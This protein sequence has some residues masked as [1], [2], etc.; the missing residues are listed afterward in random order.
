MRSSAVTCR[1]QDVYMHSFGAYF[2]AFSDPL[3]EPEPSSTPPIPNTDHRLMGFKTYVWA[4]L[5]T[6]A[7]AVAYLGHRHEGI[8]FV[9]GTAIGMFLFPAV[10]LG[11]V[12]LVGAAFK[13]RPSITT[14]RAIFFS[15]FGLTVLS[16]FGQ[17]GRLAGRRKNQ[18]LGIA[19]CMK[20]AH[21]NAAYDIDA[22]MDVRKYCECALAR[23]E[24]NERMTM[25]D[26]EEL[27]DRNSVLAHELAVPCVQAAMYTAI[28]SAG[29]LEGD[30]TSDT[31]AVLDTPK[32]IKVKVAIGGVEYYFL[33]DSGASD[34][35]VSTSLEKKL[36]ATGAIAGY[37]DSLGYEM[38]NGDIIHCRRAIVNG[39]RVGGFNADSC[40]VAI[41]DGD[42]DY[43]LGK[44]FLDKFSSWSFIEGGTK[45]VLVK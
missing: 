23:I 2:P 11:L 14:Q 35:I 3:M 13:I 42:I 39:V 21:D 5:A 29:R 41:Y 33:F 9:L 7:I 18:E 8:P 43:L 30:A 34:I 45:L 4:I 20:A 31:I 17:M 38:A 26:L 24:E 6:V 12:W 37:L 10:I 16:Q 15:V 28:G 25:A 27:Q 1:D 22:V 44:S 36:A 32:G 19:A 40:V